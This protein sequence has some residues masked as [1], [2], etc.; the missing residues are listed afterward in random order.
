MAI[1]NR[2][3][4]TQTGKSNASVSQ[5]NCLST[6]CEWRS[7]NSGWNLS[8]ASTADNLAACDDD[9]K[10]LFSH[11]IWTKS[12]R[13]N[14]HDLLVAVKRSDHNLNNSTASCHAGEH[15]IQQNIGLENKLYL[16]N[17]LYS[18]GIKLLQYRPTSAMFTIM[19]YLII[20]K[21]RN[22]KRTHS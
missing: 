20:N 3:V 17:I 8:N 5:H 11:V 13:Q 21:K 1:K 7:D 4:K 22:N 6:T 14:N 10:R 15:G 19:P 16:P 9:T 12:K 2:N 18:T